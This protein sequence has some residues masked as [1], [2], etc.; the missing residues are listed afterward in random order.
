MPE[1]RFKPKQTAIMHTILQAADAGDFLTLSELKAIVPWGP[2]VT[3]PAIL[4]SVRFLIKHG[5][6]EKG[7]YKGAKIVPTALAYS[8]FRTSK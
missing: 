3:L 1:F 4:C 7:D 2:T 8:T 5:F 6:L